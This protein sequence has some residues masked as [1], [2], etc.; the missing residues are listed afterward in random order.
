LIKQNYIGIT[1]L[2]ISAMLFALYIF[3]I[4][5]PEMTQPMSVRVFLYLLSSFCWLIFGIGI[6][7]RLPWARTG[8][9][10]TA[11]VYIIDSLEEPSSIFEA[12]NRHDYA[13]LGRLSIGL[14]FFF[15]VL[16]FFTRKTVKAQFTKEAADK[17]GIN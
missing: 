2:G 4:Y 9:I 12:I 1:L 14:I 15:S 10:I 8:I 16:I 13:T 5:I 3:L 17:S 11:I 7:R 6:L